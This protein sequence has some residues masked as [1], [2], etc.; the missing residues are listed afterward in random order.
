MQTGYQILSNGIEEIVQNTPLDQLDNIYKTEIAE[1][2]FT[3]TYI[4]A[5]DI[6]YE[7]L[8]KDSIELN[9]F[10]ILLGLIKEYK[11]S[12]LAKLFLGDLKRRELWLP[13][14]I[15]AGDISPLLIRRS[16]EKTNKRLGSLQ[17]SC[18][19][20][21]LDLA[22]KNQSAKIRHDIYGEKAGIVKS[23]GAWASIR[24]RKPDD[25]LKCVRDYIEKPL[26]PTAS[27]PPLP[28]QLTIAEIKRVPINED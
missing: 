6:V 23:L 15:F 14:R 17:E 3:Q 10:S 24:Y 26:E 2:S 12:E 9:E 27:L 8:V 18:G 13:D 11:E 7:G 16:I 19:A 5:R 28:K 25:P 20:Y 1:A 22:I 21:A 4:K